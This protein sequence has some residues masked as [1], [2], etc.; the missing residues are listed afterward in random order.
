MNWTIFFQ[1]L[2]DT[3]K[4]ISGLLK[5][6]KNQFNDLEKDFPSDH[7]NSLNSYYEKLSNFNQN[8]SKFI[9]KSK[10]LLKKGQNLHKK[11]SSILIPDE[12]DWVKWD[13]R[14]LISYVPTYKM[15]D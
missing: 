8:C 1:D 7:L 15:L 5:I 11:A 4:A 9:Q 10:K 2:D 6:A 14:Q 13:S 3:M 12:F